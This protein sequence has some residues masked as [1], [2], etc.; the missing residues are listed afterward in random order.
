M[1]MTHVRWL[2]GLLTT[3]MLASCSGS[4][5]ATAPQPDP[6][7]SVLTI[8]LTSN[9]TFS[10]AEV[11]I[12]AGTTVRW[13][14]DTAIFHTVTPDDPNQPGVWE[15]RTTTSAGEVFRHTFGETGQTY[16]YHCEP[17]LAQGM[18]G[19]VQVR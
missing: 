1:K 18:I 11:E 16:T 7:P 14:N 12:D 9:L 2:A 15:R 6:D 3:A 13:V 8:R 10:P 19:T 4:D 17:H 5:G